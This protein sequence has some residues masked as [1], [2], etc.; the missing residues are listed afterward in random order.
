M[1]KSLIAQEM[2][3]HWFRVPTPKNHPYMQKKSKK[4]C[5]Y[6][7]KCFNFIFRS[8]QIHVS[9]K[10]RYSFSFNFSTPKNHPEWQQQRKKY[11]YEHKNSQIMYFNQL[12]FFCCL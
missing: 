11:V 7:L 6:S 5:I 9:L 3:F 10:N 12:K 1:K 2:L 8:L 4:G